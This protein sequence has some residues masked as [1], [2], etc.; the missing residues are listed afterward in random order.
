[1][2]I[3]T[4]VS[5][6]NF[7]DNVLPVYGNK[8]VDAPRWDESQKMFIVDEYQSVSG[9]RYLTGVR[10]TDRIA[11]VERIALV[12]SW[13]YVNAIEL[14][15]FNGQSMELIQKKD[16]GLNVFKKENMIR[17]DSVEMVKNYIQGALKLNRCTMSVSQIEHQA[18]SLVNMC[19]KS[20]LDDDFNTRLTQV[21]RLL[22]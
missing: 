3:L 14:Y 17:N 15:A 12:Y 4:S 6:S 19:Y 10:F 22:R 8:R 13:T 20:F 5:E 9:Y 11:I 2:A 18:K 1:M 7:L 21:V 16:Y